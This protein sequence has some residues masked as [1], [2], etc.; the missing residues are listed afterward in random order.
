MPKSVKRSKSNGLKSRKR[1]GK[2]SRNA[3]KMR[4]TRKNKGGSMTS[5]TCKSLAVVGGVA[6][7]AMTGF[8]I[9]PEDVYKWADCDNAKNKA[10]QSLK[11]IRLAKNIINGKTNKSYKYDITE[12]IELDTYIKGFLGNNKKNFNLLH[13]KKN[14][15]LNV[16]KD[17]YYLY[18]DDKNIDT[19][20]SI[21]FTHMN[22]YVTKYVTFSKRKFHIL[23][24]LLKINPEDIIT[25]KINKM[26]EKINNLDKNDTYNVEKNEKLLKEIKDNKDKTR[27]IYASF[28]N[29]AKYVCEKNESL[30]NICHG[31]ASND[32]TSEEEKQQIIASV[33]QLVLIPIAEFEKFIENGVYPLPKET[34]YKN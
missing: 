31:F 27:Y 30:K 6:G 9:N 29:A 19:F 24:F 14:T 16:N 33:R 34:H 21:A 15:G 3:K 32:S 4:K 1:P 18:D 10:F 25:E 11:E 5:V 8:G 26:E 12:N 20:R 22:R 23:K 17:E 28:K 2:K 7:W 13:I